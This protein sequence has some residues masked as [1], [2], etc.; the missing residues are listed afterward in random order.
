MKNKGDWL[1]DFLGHNV[2]FRK[3]TG[4]LRPGFEDNNVYDLY[5]D[6]SN[7]NWVLE[8]DLGVPEKDDKLD[9]YYI[10]SRIEEYLSDR[11]GYFESDIAYHCY[12]TGYE[13]DLEKVRSWHH[14][15]DFDIYDDF[16]LLDR[17]STQLILYINKKK[18][19]YLEYSGAITN[20][21]EVSYALEDLFKFLDKKYFEDLIDISDTNAYNTCIEILAS[22]HRSHD[23]LI[24]YKR[25]MDIISTDKL[26]SD[27][28]LRS[29]DENARFFRHRRES[30]TMNSTKLF[31]QV[32]KESSGEGF[33]SEDKDTILRLFRLN[34]TEVV[35]TA[36]EFEYGT[37]CF[38]VVAG[39]S[40]PMMISNLHDDL[41]KLSLRNNIFYDEEENDEGFYGRTYTFYYQDEE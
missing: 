9:P 19:D 41:R 17:T 20:T 1:N 40:N 15:F 33:S 2:Y 14:S 27:K 38:E 25:L 24:S 35:D 11:L 37:D 8:L 26:K 28:D 18:V 39:N 31:E 4:L 5:E 7:K 21:S 29:K 32:F 12:G 10:K 36:E 6:E 22:P 16:I 30:N 34:K 3:D 23:D 13:N